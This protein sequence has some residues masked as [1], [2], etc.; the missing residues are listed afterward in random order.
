MQQVGACKRVQVSKNG[1]G[2]A[3][4]ST[5]EEAQMAISR[6]NGSFVMGSSIVV[7]TYTKKSPG[8][9]GGGFRGGM[10]GGGM[11]GGGMM[12][13]GMMGGGFQQN[14]WMQRQTI[15]IW[16]PQFQKKGMGKGGAVEFEVQHPERTVWIGSLAEG[17]SHTDLRPIFMQ[18]GTVKRIQVLKKGTGFVLFS[19]A[20]EATLAISS[21]NGTMVNGQAIQVDTY[22]KK[23]K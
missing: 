10:M 3:F 22:T 13:G 21:L 20:E 8:K 16:Q 1:T 23:S 2:F 14:Q 7:D 9:G 5:A 4:F 17:T 11:M 12:G 18:A 19:T 15:P 6:L